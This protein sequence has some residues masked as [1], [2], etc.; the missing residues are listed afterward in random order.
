MPESNFL[1]DNFLPKLEKA[2]VA[3]AAKKEIAEWQRDFG[4][5][6]FLTKHYVQSHGQLK[7]PMAD[8]EDETRP[9]FATVN[10]FLGKPVDAGLHHQRR[11]CLFLLGDAGMGKTSLL[12]LL[13][14]AYVT[15]LSASDFQCE[16][17]RLSEVTFEEL[18]V[19]KSPR[20][21]IL[22]LDGLNED[23]KAGGDLIGYVNDL[24]QATRNFHRV[25]I[26]CRTAY[27]C[28]RRDPAHAIGAFVAGAY[29]CP[30]LY[31]A[32]FSEGLKEK[33]LKRRFGR[34]KDGNRERV[35]RAI[36][37]AG[38]FQD[39][40]LL[41]NHADDFIQASGNLGHAFDALETITEAWLERESKTSK[42]SKDAMR[43]DCI[44]LAQRMQ[45]ESS[46]HRTANIDG[47]KIIP[48][49]ECQGRSLLRIVAGKEY[50]FTHISFQ[51]YFVALGLMTGMHPS[52]KQRLP[53]SEFIVTLLIHGDNAATAWRALDLTNVSFHRVALRSPDFARCLLEASDY[54]D[55][56]VLSASFD[57]AILTSWSAP[58]AS[59]QG[60][61]FQGAKATLSDL[62]AAIFTGVSFAHATFAESSLTGAQ[63]ESCQLHH[64]LFADADLGATQ[65]AKSMIEDCSFKGASLRAVQ[66]KQVTFKQSRF[67]HANFSG[68][69]FEDCT[70][71]GMS[72][73]SADMRRA[74]LDGGVVSAI[75][76][77]K[78]THWETAAW[79]PEVASKLKLSR[80]VN[81]KNAVG[82]DKR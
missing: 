13:K 24:L 1:P 7:K 14:A 33:Y 8:R 79:S 65:F 11:N 81:E 17:R 71:E 47:L 50:R 48:A 30:T 37:D 51:E 59:F 57:Q 62:Q 77:G 45:M 49:L 69:R 68:A 10:R 9:V 72:L 40:P 28:D 44:N 12:L 2:L 52:G 41:F 29:R 26:A 6:V 53:S 73:Q 19:I 3:G 22:L 58:R 75:K 80:Q 23:P 35:S 5:A 66:F 76:V 78:I 20:R 56:S 25:I 63:F 64:T 18:G 55:S 27:F 4:D 70:F 46:R 43:D 54:S 21:T 15:G 42:V 60:G 32:A 82:C 39:R 67:D 61:S 34:M 16:L 38:T 36:H 74:T 31:L